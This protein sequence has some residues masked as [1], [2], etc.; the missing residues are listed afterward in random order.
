MGMAT[1]P[2]CV[3]LLHVS[4]WKLTAWKSAAYFS[5]LVEILVINVAEPMNWSKN[6]QLAGYIFVFCISC[7]LRLPL[8]TDFVATG[9]LAVLLCR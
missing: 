4:P 8:L 7:A 9:L 2:G 3:K 6:K 5:W 1:L